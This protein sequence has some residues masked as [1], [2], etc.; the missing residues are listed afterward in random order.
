MFADKTD[1][2]Q[3]YGSIPICYSGK[4]LCYLTTGQIVPEDIKTPMENLLEYLFMGWMHNWI[5][6]NYCG[7]W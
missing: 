6:Q 4:P 7:R 5:R 2:T 3:C 1:E